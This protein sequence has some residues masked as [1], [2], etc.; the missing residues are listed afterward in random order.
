M[1][2]SD[3][4]YLATIEK[5]LQDIEREAYGLRKIIRHWIDSRVGG[6]SIQGQSETEYICQI[7]SNEC[8]T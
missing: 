8:D 2:V 5:K 1:T 3:T 6:E 7:E 4:V